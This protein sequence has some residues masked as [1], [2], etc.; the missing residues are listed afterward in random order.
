M[1]YG[2]DR[3]AT[4]SWERAAARGMRIPALREE[5]TLTGLPC[6]FLAAAAQRL[7]PGFTFATEEW[8]VVNK[9]GAP[10]AFLDE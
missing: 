6:D 4:E 7:Q 8:A 2:A 9:R 1:N 5:V 3:G 10:G